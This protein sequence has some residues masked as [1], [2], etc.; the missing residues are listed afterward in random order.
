M[1]RP[2]AHAAPKSMWARTLACPQERPEHVAHFAFAAAFDGLARIT[3]VPVSITQTEP[4]SAK[5]FFAVN[6]RPE[7][8]LC[9]CL[10]GY[11]CQAKTL[12]LEG[13]V[14]SD[15]SKRVTITRRRSACGRASKYDFY[16]KLVLCRIRLLAAV[17]K[18]GVA[19][20][21]G[22]PFSIATLSLFFQK[23]KLFSS[24]ATINGHCTSPCRCLPQRLP[25]Q[26]H[27]AAQVL[28]PVVSKS[29]KQ[30]CIEH[31]HRRFGII[32]QMCN[33]SS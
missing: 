18:E 29:Q 14:L 33:W 21:S 30:Y 3:S 24:P 9:L 10:L 11:I 32:W 2:A 1:R 8:T 31:S 5:L 17:G 25:W 12:S 13:M 15:G 27:H 23:Y 4:S 6:H 19:S 16:G 26:L 20:C 22:L 7:G 28:S